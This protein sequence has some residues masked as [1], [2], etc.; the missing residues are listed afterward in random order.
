ML[1]LKFIRDNKDLVEKSIKSKNVD[2]NLNKLLVKDD[3]RRS[4]INQV[5][6]L[7]AKRN[8][9]N[10]QISNKKD[11]DKNI[12]E[13]RSLSSEIKTLDKGLNT[14]DKPTIIEVIS[15]IDA[16]APKTWMP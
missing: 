3:K 16:L 15:D 9:V 8:L 2:F 1:S 13:M 14:H 12:D 6:Q 11:V 5:E 4:I 10:K 7:K